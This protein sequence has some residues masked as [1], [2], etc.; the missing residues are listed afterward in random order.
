MTHFLIVLFVLFTEVTL[1]WLLSLKL[2]DASIIDI[3]WGFGYVNVAVVCVL[4]SLIYFDTT[5]SYSQWLLA[6]LVIIWGM[7]LTIHL[8]VRN[9]GK[10]EDYRYVLMRKKRGDSWWLLSYPFVFL[11]QM[12][13]MLIISLPVVW[14]LASTEGRSIG[15][16]EIIA[17][18]L[19]AVGFVFE[20]VGDYQLKRF[21]ETRSGIE[22]ILNT[23]LWKYTRH[24]NYFGDALQWWAFFLFALPL[25]NGW[26]TIISPIVMTLFLV[27]VS[28]VAMLEK[29]LQK[30]KPHYAEYIAKTPA[31]IPWFP[32][33]S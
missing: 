11:F 1:L 19:W 31:F 26:L 15:P 16:L 22:Q 21:K 14:V 28:G 13:L 6:S 2:K 27:K 20:S 5:L 3:F 18:L 7:R 24:P 9:I 17:C 32:R 23:G 8:G 4:V 30:T 25:L 10:G 33:S 12:S 29:G